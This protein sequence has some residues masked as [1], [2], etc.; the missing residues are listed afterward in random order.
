MIRKVVSLFLA[1]LMLM[2]T[3]AVPV[4]VAE[5]NTGINVESGT[6]GDQNSGSCGCC[7][8]AGIGNVSFIELQGSEKNKEVAEVLSNTE[9]KNL[10]AMLIEKGYKPKIDDTMANKLI[11]TNE[12]GASE[13][14]VVEMHFEKDP[15]SDIARII[16]TSNKD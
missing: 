14:V 10:K 5:M 15:S 6:Y 1:M 7:G 12:S 16:F 9:V 4:A 11:L 13:A 8:N 3:I 2:A